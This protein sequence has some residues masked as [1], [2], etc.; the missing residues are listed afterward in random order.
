M[1]VRAGPGF[2]MES[3]M[4][5]LVLA[6]DALKVNGT[7]PWTPEYIEECQHPEALEAKTVR[8]S[9]I[10][11]IFS[12][13]FYNGT[14]TLKAIVDT[15]KTLGIEGFVLASN[16]KYGDYIAEPIPF[17]VPSILIPSVADSQVP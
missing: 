7:F 10:I 14:S 8:G 16:P 17:D 15:V 4:H 2:R 3:V 1:Y 11:C 13:G 5:K 12:S 9:V 6:K